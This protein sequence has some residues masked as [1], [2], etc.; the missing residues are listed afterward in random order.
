[1]CP[2]YHN[3]DGREF[4]LLNGIIQGEYWR[5][6]AFCSQDFGKERVLFLASW[7][8]RQI[9]AIIREND[10]NLIGVYPLILWS[11]AREGSIYLI[12]DIVVSNDNA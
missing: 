3:R 2:I 9:R 5:Q 10:L 8:Q 1:M 12:G 7:V 6:F 11:A 4:G